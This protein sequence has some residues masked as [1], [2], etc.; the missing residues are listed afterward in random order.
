[1]LKYCPDWIMR[2]QI[3][4]LHSTCFFVNIFSSKTRIQLYLRH[5]WVVTSTAP[6]A[7]ALNTT[8]EH[9]RTPITFFPLEGK[10]GWINV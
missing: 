7:V 8:A 6:H 10:Q 4:S 1:M 9:A 3:L 5:Y 2:M